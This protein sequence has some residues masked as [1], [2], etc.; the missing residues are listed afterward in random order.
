MS[1]VLRDLDA[2]YWAEMSKAE[3]ARFERDWVTDWA[4]EIV[5]ECGTSKRS[6][7]AEAKAEFETWLNQEGWHA[8]DARVEV[9]RTAD[10]VEVE[11]AGPGHL[12]PGVSTLD[13]WHLAQELMYE[14]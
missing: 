2:V 6:A 7:R 14:R 8:H 1:A 5:A 10:L 11:P 13:A 3:S 4:Q 9:A 12:E